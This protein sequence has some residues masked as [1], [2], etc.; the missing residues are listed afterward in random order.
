MRGGGSGCISATANIN[1]AAI[2]E[3]YRNWKSPD[4]DVL[5]QKLN[6]IRNT[7]MAYPMIPALKA[8][9]AHYAKDP[10]WRTVRPPL[11]SLDDDQVAALVAEW[12]KQGFDMPGL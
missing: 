5:Q 7:A 8:T 3:L 10:Q 1:P 4:A 12:N 6:K 11:V 9:V 2:D